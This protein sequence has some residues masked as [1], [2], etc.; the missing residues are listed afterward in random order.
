[1]KNSLDFTFTRDTNFEPRILYN[2]A[3]KPIDL[4]DQRESFSLRVNIDDNLDTKIIIFVRM[5]G[6]SHESICIYTISP[7]SLSCSGIQN[8][9]KVTSI[10]HLD[11]DNCRLIHINL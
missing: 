7:E 5:N 11:G 8:L 6:D 3:G 9:E 4:K 1:M 10:L 2:E